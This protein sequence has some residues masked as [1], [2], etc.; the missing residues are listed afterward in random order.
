MRTTNDIR[1]Q[2]LD[3]F[4]AHG[5]QEVASSP[6]VPRN[7]PSLMFAN[8]GMVQFKNLFTGQEQRAYKRA[9]TAQK[10]VRAGGKHN[11]LENVGYTARHHT[12]FEMLGNFSFGDYFKEDAIDMAW[13]LITKEFGL[14]KEK[15]LVTIYGEDEE[16][17]GLWRK[18]AG[19]GDERIIRINTSDN[20]WQMGDTG[21]CGPC[22]EIF[23]DHGAHIQGGPPGSPDEDG[24]RFIEIWNLVFMQFEQFADGSRQPLPRPSIDTGMGLERIS[25][26]LQG[27]HSNYEIDLFQKL[28]TASGN[29]T[30]T[31]PNGPKAASH[32]VIADHL[33]SSAFLIADG[34]LPSN[35]GRG[36]VLRRIMRRAMRHAHLLGAR[37]PILYR[38]LPSLIGVMGDHYQELRRAEALIS[39]TLKL[40]ESRFQDTLARGLKMLE[41]ATNKLGEGETLAGSV[42][43]ML[44]D[45]CGFPVDLTA[46]ILRQQGRKLDM[47]GFEAS[48]EAQRAKARKAWGGSGEQATE[49]LWFHLRDRWGASEFL[50]YQTPE[51]EG[52]IQAIVKDGEE[53]LTANPDE[54]IMLMVNQSPFYGESGGQMGDSGV[55]TSDNGASV[56]IEDTKRKLDGLIIHTGK[57]VTGQMRVGDRVR[58]SIDQAK[59]QR[60]RANHSVTHLA[61]AALRQRLGSHVTQKGSLVGDQAMRFDFSHSHPLSP[62]DLAAVEAKVNEEIRANSPVSTR[63]MT[64]EAAIEAGAMAL[65]GEKYGDEVRVVSMGMPLPAAHTNHAVTSIELCGGTHVERTGEIGLFKI[66]NESGVAAGV[67][68]IECLTGA[69]AL[70]YLNGRDG[71]VRSLATIL[72]SSVDDIEV[73]VA[74]LQ[75]DKKLLERELSQLRRKLAVM[76][77]APDQQTGPSLASSTSQT[78]SKLGSINLIIREVGTIPAQ[79]L[80]P[81]VDDLKRAN[82]SS[83]IAIFAVN[84]DKISLVVGVTPDL[85]TKLSAVELV[86]ELVPLLG[87]KGGGGRPDLAQGGGHDQSG[88]AKARQAL[89]ERLHTLA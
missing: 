25:A 18:I 74:T 76:G 54:E 57:V 20:F 15:L 58:L 44:Y 52:I 72:K 11:D 8:S 77:Q 33:R 26:V 75:D 21:P 28:L 4:V 62:D 83:V 59:R 71:Q 87:G 29:L 37:D 73:R 2:F 60:L 82:P 68:R 23:Y 39:E 16:A 45:T 35:E 89:S 53:L 80:K 55:I 64:P 70:D 5:H 7:D 84:E 27:V 13:R 63:L 67:R 51:A 36:Y 69:A 41:E 14:A 48:M 61:H 79:E 9:T 43:F 24:D 47:A 40:E 50:G 56:A 65:F 12:F 38:L 78:D 3:F 30:S 88:I 49:Q 31:D 1:K 32:R 81:L 85:T 34:V 86:K 46:D 10:S 17:A 42:A 6:L 22:S 66:T 19:L